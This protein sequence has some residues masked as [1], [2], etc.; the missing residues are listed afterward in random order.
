MTIRCKRGL[1]SI[2]E[3]ANDR[4]NQILH[5]YV[6]VEWGKIMYAKIIQYSHNEIVD[7]FDN[8]KYEYQQYSALHSLTYSDCKNH[9]LMLS[10]I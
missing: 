9:D 2:H 7:V 8:P 1:V 3:W 10:R 6:N 4:N 5:Q